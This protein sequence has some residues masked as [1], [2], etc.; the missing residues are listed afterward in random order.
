MHDSGVWRTFYAGIHLYAALHNKICFFVEYMIYNFFD[1][2]A[3]SRTICNM[4][5]KRTTIYYSLTE[6]E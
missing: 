5:T 3:L 4:H 6:D 1:M 2:R